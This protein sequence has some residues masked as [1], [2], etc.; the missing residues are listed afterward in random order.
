MNRS[1]WL[2]GLFGLLAIAPL[3]VSSA[4]AQALRTWVS[5]TGDDANVCSR[6]QPCKTLAV[7]LGKTAVNGEINCLDPVSFAA[8]TIIN[9]SVT[10]DC[11]GTF[12]SFDSSA[13][14]F[15]LAI[16][17]P[18]NTRVILR[19]LSF[20]GYGSSTAGIAFNSGTVLELDNVKFEGFTEAAVYVDRNSFGA[21]TVKNSSFSDMKTGIKLQT[22]VGNIVASISGSSFNNL[23]AHGVEANVNVYVAVN[24]SVFTALGGTAILAG[25][26]TSTV[27]AENNLVTNTHTAISA[28]VAGAKITASRNALYGNS[29]A[30][31]VAAGATLLSAGENKFDINPGNPATGALGTK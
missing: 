16:N 20:N 6:S 22:I 24:S 5:A 15:A 10:I 31:N 11:E 17:A 29:K 1:A 27:Y 12:G 23:N 9:A 2:L 25:A 7:T 30:F 18:A 19:N 4:Q 14:P 26:A 13:Q 3:P 21:L 28:S 8:N